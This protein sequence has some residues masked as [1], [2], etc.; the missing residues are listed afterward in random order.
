[1]AF[2]FQKAEILTKKVKVTLSLELLE[3]TLTYEEIEQRLEIAIR[4][5]RLPGMSSLVVD[6]MRTSGSRLWDNAQIKVESIDDNQ[7]SLQTQ[8]KS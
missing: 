3:S 5:D 7:T 8:P 6:L 4:C 2:K 1:M